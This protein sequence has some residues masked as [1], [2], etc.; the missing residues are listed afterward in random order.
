M[1]KNLDQLEKG[2]KY[3]GDEFISIKMDKDI[4]KEINKYVEK[5]GDV[6]SRILRK[7]VKESCEY[8][9]SKMQDYAPT[10][11][12]GDL[13]ELIGEIPINLIT[14]DKVSL[15]QDAKLVVQLDLS[16]KKFRKIIW[17]DKG[18]GIY[19][20]NRRLI[21]PVNAQFLYYEIDGVLHRSKTVKG[22]RGKRFIKSA[23]N[24]S[25]LIIKTKIRSALK[26][27]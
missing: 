24:T 9:R 2:T 11:E 19:G 21:R 1:L 25:K 26:D 10:G 20:P 23:V 12:T 13:K 4:K 18:T 7:K 6:L 8:V 3:V 14:I 17:V 16:S 5:K 22:Q 15:I 27:I